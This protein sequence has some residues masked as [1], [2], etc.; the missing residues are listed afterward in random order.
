MNSTLTNTENKTTDGHHSGRFFVHC[1]GTGGVFCSRLITNRE[2]L[3]VWGLSYRAARKPK[4]RR[5]N[6]A[7]FYF[8]R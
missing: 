4:K 8:I 5:R 1:W 7:L 6:V 3:T 2:T